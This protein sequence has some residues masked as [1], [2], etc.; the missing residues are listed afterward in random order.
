M[1]YDSVNTKI[2][3]G[4]LIVVILQLFLGPIISI[5]AVVPNLLLAY[6]IV[7]IVIRPDKMHLIFAFVMG[8]I[9]DLCF[10]GPV[11]AMAFVMVVFSFI[12]AKVLLRLPEINLGISLLTIGFSVFF[13]ELFYGI[14]QVSIMVNASLVDVLAYRIL[15]CTIYDVI[16]AFI[17]FA[18][19]A[20]L[21]AP[22]VTASDTIQ[23]SVNEVKTSR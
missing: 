10:N 1:R 9:Y 8:L 17:M 22:P 16:L 3:I 21:I 11:G 23:S 12:V 19:M 2:Y 14:L 5:N 18:I 6:T 7:C 20:R 13:V 4:G 15:P